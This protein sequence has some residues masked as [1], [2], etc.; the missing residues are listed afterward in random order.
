[1]RTFNETA[2]SFAWGI[3]AGLTYIVSCF[4][5]VYYLPYF[6]AG[7]LLSMTL[8]FF[9]WVMTSWAE[10]LLFFPALILLWSFLI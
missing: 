3:I 5:D 2:T 4:F 6:I 10:R 7:Y 9:F 1:M 8:Y